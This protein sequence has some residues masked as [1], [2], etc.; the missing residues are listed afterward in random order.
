MQKT[1][2]VW[3]VYHLLYANA[4]ERSYRGR[5]L[6]PFNDILFYWNLF[7]WL[8]P[9]IFWHLL[10]HWVAHVTVINFHR[11]LGKGYI[12]LMKKTNNFL[13]LEIIFVKVQQRDHACRGSDQLYNS[14]KDPGDY[15]CKGSFED[16]SEQK[17]M[18]LVS[19]RSFM[20]DKSHF[21]FSW[22]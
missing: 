8:Y 1:A 9:S 18:I 11:L 15:I 7:K 5:S 4:D 14:C 13:F 3:Y 2:L 10:F 12:K 16:S 22:G 6:I 17:R 19:G 21:R 20:I